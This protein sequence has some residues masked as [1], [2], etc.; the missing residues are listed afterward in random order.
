VN[1]DALRGLCLSV[2]QRA[3]SFFFAVSSGVFGGP[4]AAKSCA[5]RRVSH[6]VVRFPPPGARSASSK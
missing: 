2:F 4:Q 3:R 6:A 5:F 1:V